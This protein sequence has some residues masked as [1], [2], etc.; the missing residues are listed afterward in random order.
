MRD[1]VGKREGN[2]NLRGGV[3][4]RRKGGVPLHGGPEK[5]GSGGRNDI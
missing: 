4:E 1:Q 2:E 3:Q 5:W